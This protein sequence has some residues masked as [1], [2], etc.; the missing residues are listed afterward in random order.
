V[1]RE[2]AGD[3]AVW[4]PPLDAHAWATAITSLMSDAPRR[5]RLIAAGRERARS[6]SYRRA[7][8]RLASEYEALVPALA[9]VPGSGAPP[10]GRAVGGGAR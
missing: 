6:F 10:V 2:V 3:A 7:A 8:E 9:K 1:L 5:A 4:A